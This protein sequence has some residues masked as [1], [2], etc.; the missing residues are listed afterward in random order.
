[1]YTTDSKNT[2]GTTRRKC[3]Y[4]NNITV[5]MDDFEA[6]TRM[7]FGE[8]YQ[9]FINKSHECDP[10]PGGGRC[11]FNKDNKHSDAIF[12]YGGHQELKF[13]RVFDD[14]IVVVYTL[15]SIF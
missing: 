6:I 12:Y 9:G 4:S 8:A 15:E 1:M 14:Q 5:Y 3:T 11:S 7:Y 13:K 10:L 2:V